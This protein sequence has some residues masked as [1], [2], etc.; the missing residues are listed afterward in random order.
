MNRE[1][2]NALNGDAV[3]LAVKSEGVVCSGNC[4][5]S[6][7]PSNFVTASMNPSTG[8]LVNRNLTSKLISFFV[9]LFFIFL[10]FQMTGVFKVSTIEGKRHG[11]N[12]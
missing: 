10:L 7:W 8:T 5:S 9:L 12:T 4:Y 1:A 11:G 6:I 2:I 3:L